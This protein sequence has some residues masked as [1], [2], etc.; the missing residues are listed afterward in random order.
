VNFL[1]RENITV[2]GARE[3][4]GYKPPPLIQNDGYGDLRPRRPDVIG[5][6][7][8]K[9]RIVFGLVRPDRKSLDTE[10]SLLE[11]NVFLDHNAGKGDQ[12]SVVYVLIPAALAQEFTSVITHYIHREYWHRIIPVE[13]RHTLHSIPPAT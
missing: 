9:H 11:Y 5:V 1:A 2:H 8:E 4:E 7:S 12:A 6:D 3:V 13:S 10:E